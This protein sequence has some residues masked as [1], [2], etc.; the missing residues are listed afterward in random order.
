MCLSCT[1]HEVPY[2][3]TTAIECNRRHIYII[4]KKVNRKIT[5]VFRTDLNIIK[6]W[7]SQAEGIWL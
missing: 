2:Y 4:K 3:G 7:I 1:H 5:I 6:N